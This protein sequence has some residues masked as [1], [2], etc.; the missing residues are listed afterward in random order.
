MRSEYLFEGQ[1]EDGCWK[2]GSVLVRRSEFD[3]LTNCWCPTTN[4][5]I[6]F[7][8]PVDQEIARCL[9]K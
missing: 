4:L 8:I 1:T 2:G 9:I 5:E 7:Y 6:Q 3:G